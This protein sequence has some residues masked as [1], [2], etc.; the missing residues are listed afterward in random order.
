MNTEMAH[1]LKQTEDGLFMISR[2]WLGK[3]VNPLLR[4]IIINDGMAKA[5]AEHCCVKFRNLLEI[6]P[7][8]YN[9]NRQGSV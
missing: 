8:L 2:F 1:I 3:T 9:E 6:L 5:M 4:K 7:I